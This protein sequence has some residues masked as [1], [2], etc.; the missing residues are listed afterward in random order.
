MSLEDKLVQTLARVEKG[1]APKYHQ[2]N[3]ETGKLLQKGVKKCNICAFHDTQMHGS[4]GNCT[5]AETSKFSEHR[6]Q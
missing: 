3:A 2:K 4:A 6:T 1:G 5:T